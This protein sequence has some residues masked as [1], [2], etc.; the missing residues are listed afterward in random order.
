MLPNGSLV[1]GR[2][3]TLAAQIAEGSQ[4]EATK[5]EVAK[6]D[7]RGSSERAADSVGELAANGRR[8]VRLSLDTN[9]LSIPACACAYA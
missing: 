9:W 3:K 2:E 1:E 7:G 6:L 8:R 4:S 5:P